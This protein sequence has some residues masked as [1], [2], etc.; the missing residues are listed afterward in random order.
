MFGQIANDEGLVSKQ[1]LLEWD[2]ISKLL[3]DGLLNQRLNLT[4]FGK[5]RQRHCR[6]M[7]INIE[8]FLSF[9]AALDDLFVFDEEERRC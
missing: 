3:S 7:S 2:E 8:G 4:E 5:R 1:A 9:N 6:R